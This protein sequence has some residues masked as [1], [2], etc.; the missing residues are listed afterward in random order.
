MGARLKLMLGVKPQRDSWTLPRRS[1]SALNRG[2]L[3]DRARPQNRYPRPCIMSRLSMQT[4]IHDSRYTRNRD[5]AFGDVGGQHYFA[6][7]CAANVDARGA[8]ADS[9]S[10]WR[11]AGSR[12]CKS[13]DPQLSAR[14]FPSCPKNTRMPLPQANPFAQHRF[15]T[16]I[17]RS[18]FEGTELPA[19][20][21]D[22]AKPERRDPDN[23][24]PA[25]PPA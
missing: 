17:C 22:N 11:I 14:R 1:A 6:K 20:V 19:G 13:G 3:A 12:H 15:F 25:L 4:G 18:N 24:Q 8:T 5:R 7:P 9:W 23:P 2:S 16:F 10:S 21:L